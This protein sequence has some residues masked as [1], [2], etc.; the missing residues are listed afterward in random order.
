MGFT[1]QELYSLIGK[2]DG[3]YL[4]FEKGGLVRPGRGEKHN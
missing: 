2:F 1:G 3:S 4:P